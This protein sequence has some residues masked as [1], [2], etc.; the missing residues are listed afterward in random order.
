MSNNL[1]L[2]CQTEPTNTIK[3]L[4][5][6][7]GYIPSGRVWSFSVVW[8]ICRVLRNTAVSMFYTNYNRVKVQPNFF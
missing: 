1:C 5:Y 7:T 6:R 2:K 4:S 8:L 3:E